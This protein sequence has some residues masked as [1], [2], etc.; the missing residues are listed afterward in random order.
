MTIMF[1]FTECIEIGQPPRA[2]WQ[3]LVDVEAWW[4]PSNPEHVAIEV[5]EHPV[6]EGTTVSFE[7]RVA[8]IRGQAQGCITRFVQGE[9]ITWEGRARYGCWGLGF[10]IT[11]GVAWT[12]EVASAG[13]RL[14]ATV[15][16]AFPGTW[17]GRFLELYTTRV[18]N[19]VDRDRAHA[20]TEL[21]WLKSHIEDG[22]S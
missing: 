7:E 8:G 11:E 4:L 14:C 15:W 9:N 20:R 17:F 19:V 22:G 13:T 16:A 2:V 12:L 21:E 6:R 18:L 5:G 10:E 3:T 1:E